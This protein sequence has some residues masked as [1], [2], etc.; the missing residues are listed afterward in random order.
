MHHNMR[1]D[2]PGDDPRH[3]L[4]LSD[5]PRSRSETLSGTC[6]C[7]WQS[8]PCVEVTKVVDLYVEHLPRRIVRTDS[9]T[10]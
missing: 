1:T 7:G 2:L 10:F 6:V 9:D 5:S 4:T 3:G 8:G